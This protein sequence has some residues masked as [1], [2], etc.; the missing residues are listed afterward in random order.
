MKEDK[1]VCEEAQWADIRIFLAIYRHKTL[2]IAAKRLG[3]DTSTMSRRL[4]AL[5]EALGV[6]LFERTRAGL[7]AT[8]SAE[9]MLPAAEAMDAA[10]GRITRD[11]SSVEAS[12]EGIVRLSAS[13]GVADLFVAP[14]LPR[15][16]ELH[17]RITIELDVSRRALDLTRHEA[18]LAL[19][20]SHP[21]GS[22]LMITKLGSARWVAAGAPEVVERAGRVRSWTDVPWIAWDHDLASFPPARWLSLHAPNAKVALRTSHS[23][24]QLV[25]AEAGLG[26]VL[27][28][29]AYLKL[30]KLAPLRYA[31][32]LDADAAAWPTDDLWL[33]GH[34]ALREVPRVAAVWNFFA[35]EF[36]GFIDPKRVKTKPHT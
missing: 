15:L 17:P 5:E 34:R 14:A 24:S 26:M 30:R 21:S 6:R 36:R 10:F 32:G 4:T 29:E 35:G 12:A 9:Q 25:A 28:P 7:L 11:V 31:E 19:R 13:P 8:H 20:S 18:D 2:G 3:L 23:T 27:A 22:D 16:L 33:V 1:R